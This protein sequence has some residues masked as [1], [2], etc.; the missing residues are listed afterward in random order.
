MD[1]SSRQK[2]DAIRQLAERR[3]SGRP[4]AVRRRVGFGLNW[5]ILCGGLLAVAT[6]MGTVLSH[7]DPHMAGLHSSV[8]WA[9]AAGVLV[10][11]GLHWSTFRRRL[12]GAVRRTAG[13]RSE[14]E[15][16]MY[17]AF[18]F[19]IVAHDWPE[20][21]VAASLL[22]AG[23]A[24]HHVGHRWRSMKRRPQPAGTAA[25]PRL[26]EEG[27]QMTSTHATSTHTRRRHATEAIQV[28]TSKCTACG[29]CAEAC[30]HSVLKV[31]GPRFHR[32][33]RIVS[34]DDCR[35]CLLCVRA[36]PEGAISG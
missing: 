19:A 21:H 6:G 5:L 4:G 9:T 22:L 2:A 15:A 34:P 25:T 31:R 32:H 29:A 3:H 11:V 23:L 28:D 14:P 36:C 18:L 35:G 27:K 1:D 26:I 17:V 33:I 16:L 30:S 13:R 7:N 20:G 12:A 8:A 10:H 24:A